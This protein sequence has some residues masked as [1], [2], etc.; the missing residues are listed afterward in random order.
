MA[1]FPT[2]NKP[3]APAPAPAPAPAAAPP[4]P[5]S[6]APAPSI[7]GS[8]S[9]SGGSTDYTTAYNQALSTNQQLYN[10]ILN[11]YNSTMAYQQSQQN[12]INSGYS[13]LNANVLGQ[14][15]GVQTAANQQA[16]DDYAKAVGTTTQDMVNRG[17]GNSTV[18]TSA[19][20]G[21]Q[22]DYQKVLGQNAANFGQL[23]ANYMTQ[24]GMGQ[25]GYQNDS[26]QQIVNTA[27]NDLNWMNSISVPYPDAYAY[28]Q[29]N[30]QAG[31]TSAGKPSP[32]NYAPQ[33]P[34]GGSVSMPKPPVSP[35]PGAYPQQQG[36]GGG[37]Y[38]APM[39][40]NQGYNY[41]S[42]ADSLAGDAA[43][44][45]AYGAGVG[46]SMYGGGEDY[47]QSSDP[48]AAGYEGDLGAGYG[49]SAYYPMPETPD[50][51]DWGMETGFY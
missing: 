51:V 46:A 9:F 50:E 13:E 48:Y 49:G 19:A 22:Y 36:S 38:T 16:A 24:I 32:Y 33:S 2:W 45:G 44:Y 17:L 5:G 26:T 35:S 8:V 3:T 31:A 42:S 23:N 12:A 14:L 29:L 1:G 27:Y 30:Q 20:R 47:G 37:G 18:T 10:N 21:L 15:G 4:P 40:T 7:N 25:L 28:A 43:A 41:G 39:Y 6:M 11:G 34:G